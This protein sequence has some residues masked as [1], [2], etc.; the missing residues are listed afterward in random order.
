MADQTSSGDVTTSQYLDHL[1]TI[2]QRFKLWKRHHLISPMSFL[3]IQ[4]PH[5]K[6]KI[7]TKENI[8]KVV[9]ILVLGISWIYHLPERIFALELGIRCKYNLHLI[10][11]VDWHATLI[12]SIDYSQEIRTGQKTSQHTCQQLVYLWLVWIKYWLTKRERFDTMT[13]SFRPAIVRVCIAPSL[14]SICCC[15]SK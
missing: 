12:K 13:I 15:S 5:S 3:K 1:F 6:R 11:S 4:H 8:F 14:I 9:L 2:F 7:L 10:S